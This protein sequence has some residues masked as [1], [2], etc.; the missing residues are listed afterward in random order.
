MVDEKMPADCRTDAPRRIVVATGNP[1]KVNEIR[2]ALHVEEW[3]FVALNDLGDF[4]EPIEDGGSFEA[5]ARIKA[6]AA[7]LETGLAALADDSGLEVDALDGR[8]GVYSARYAGEAATDAENNAR[9]LGELSDVPLKLRTARFVSVL[10]FIDEH[11]GET[12][13]RGTCEGV[14]VTN[15]IGEGGFGYDPLF[16]PD[17]LHGTRTMAQLSTAQ[18]SAL[19]HRG[20][21]LRD[22]AA[23][24]GLTAVHDGGDRR[25]A[26]GE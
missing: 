20:A 19:S 4:P 10:V 9:L 1:H 17:A 21:A 8:P 6:R 3:D 5:N 13:A 25:R 18:K 22:L 2:A 14:V 7:A 12:V 24:M 16:S 15:P 23:I 11:G 26:D